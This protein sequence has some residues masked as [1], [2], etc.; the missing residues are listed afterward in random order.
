MT[1]EHKEHWLKVLGII[2]AVF[3]GAFLAF[4]VVADVTL[5]RM[6][7]PA[8][9]MKKMEK[10]MKK[11]QKRFKRLENS[12]GGVNPFEPKLTPSLVTLVKE[13]DAYKVIVDLEPLD[14]NEK[15]VSIKLENNVIT[16]SGKIEKKEHHREDIM[17]FSQTYYLNEDVQQD[18]MTKE[19]EGNKYIVTI[20]FDD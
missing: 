18:K 11:E 19:R 17:N 6:T 15:N 4:Y 2:L 14:N 7:S 13:P 5:T 3:F 1:D 20:P 10:L 8:Y 9:H 12:I 16:I